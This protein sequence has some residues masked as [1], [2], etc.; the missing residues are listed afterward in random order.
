M[1]NNFLKPELPKLSMCDFFCGVTASHAYTKE[2][3][4]YT[5]NIYGVKLSANEDSAKA[6]KITLYGFVHN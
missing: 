3:H 6:F 5:L 4:K 2:S 1:I